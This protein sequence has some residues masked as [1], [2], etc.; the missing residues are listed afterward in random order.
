MVDEIWKSVEQYQGVV[1]V[2]NLGNVRTVRGGVVVLKKLRSHPFGY[3]QCSFKFDRKNVTRTVHSLVAEA[4][5]GDRPEGLYVLHF[6]NNP[7]N[8]S[9]SNL[10]YGTPSENSEDKW[11]HGTQIHGDTV[12]WKK[13]SSQEVI[14]IRDAR[15]SGIKIKDLADRFRVS[16]AQISR[17][18]NGRQ[19]ANLEGIKPSKRNKTKFLSDLEKISV[20]TDRR[21][22]LSIAALSEKYKVSRNQV[23]CYVRKF[24]L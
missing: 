1:E 14:E 5:I 10:R 9:L 23:H 7:K 11:R 4:F 13:V 15:S 3:L 18:T 22:G 2:S 16:P 8:N 19:W 24:G 12:W 20:L 21:A 17:I 6:D